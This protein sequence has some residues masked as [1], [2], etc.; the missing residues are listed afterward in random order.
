MP[1]NNEWIDYSKT[2]YKF[3]VAKTGLYRIN[4]SVLASAGLGSVA[5][6][7]FQLWRNGK[8]VPIYTSVATGTMSGAD[9]IEFWGE[10]NDGKPDKELYRNP[11]YQLN[12]KWSLESDTSVYFLTTNP[13]GNNFRLTTVPNNVAG[14]VLPPEL[15]FMHTLGTYFRDRIHA[16]YAVN[17]DNQYLYSSSYDKGEG[18]ASGDLTH[19][20]H[21]LTFN[22]LQTYTSGPAASF[23]IGVSGNAI[24][25]RSY[26]VKINN[27]SITGGQVD[28]FNYAKSTSNFPVGVLASNTANVQVQSI[29]E[30]LVIH[31]YEFTYPR[32]FSFGGK[33]KLRI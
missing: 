2:Y 7:H 19:A 12:D 1:Y 32:K 14:N 18:W 6:E 9:Y 22:D 23:N 10:M 21:S 25:T 5:A 30:R 24:S 16:G 15:F 26:L 13:A 4:Q 11:D 33:F 29:G 27:D 20:T 17:V 3:P 31:K 28:F 8:Q